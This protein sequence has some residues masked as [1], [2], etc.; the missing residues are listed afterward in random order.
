MADLWKRQ[1]EGTGKAVN[2]KQLQDFIKEILYEKSLADVTDMVR[3]DYGGMTGAALA[4]I[5]T[6]VDASKTGD[7]TKLRPLLDFAYE[8]EFKARR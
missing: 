2:K 1:P 3:E 4:V 6:V 7:F 8:K 5:Q